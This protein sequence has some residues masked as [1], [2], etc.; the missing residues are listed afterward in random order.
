[1]RTCL[2]LRSVV[3][4][5]LL[6][7]ALAGGTSALEVRAKGARL[8]VERH[9]RQARQAVGLDGERPGRHLYLHRGVHP[10]VNEGTQGLRGGTAAV[11]GLG[12]PGR[13]R[14]HG[15]SPSPSPRGRRIRAS[16]QMLLSDF[17]RQMLPAYDA[18]QTD[19]KSP[20]YRYAKRAYF[21]VDEEPGTVEQ[22]VKIM[23]NP[24]DLL[25]AAEVLK[26][27]EG[28]GL[29]EARGF[30]VVVA[31]PGAADRRRRGGRPRLREPAG[32][33]LSAAEAGAG[34]RPARAGRQGRTVRLADSPGQRSSSSSSGRPGDPTCREE[35]P[36]V[37]PA[38]RGARR[39]RGWRSCW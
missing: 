1:M 10:D 34:L 21:I 23:D 6:S 18:M 35:L 16:E 17:R 33:A 15:P 26:A 38:V 31:G 8:R 3:A 4:A 5:A 20:V 11:R 30:T 9:R 28:G 37:Q 13:G 25:D 36:S 14:Q 22:F 7:V 24:L 29:R 39:A 19:E 27:V 32:P 12:R 2:L